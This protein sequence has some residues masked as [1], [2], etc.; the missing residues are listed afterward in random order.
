MRFAKIL[1]AALV[2]GGVA[3][4]AEYVVP[5]SSGR[6]I[7][8]PASQAAA[9]PARFSQRDFDG[10]GDGLQNFSVMAR[11]QLDF[12]DARYG[13]VRGAALVLRDRD[14]LV[15]AF[16]YPEN[17]RGRH[18][19]LQGSPM[20]LPGA[21]TVTLDTHD[22]YGVPCVMVQYSNTPERTRVFLRDGVVYQDHIM[23]PPPPV[24]QTVVVREEYWHREPVQ[25]RRHHRGK[26]D[27]RGL[28]GDVLHATA[29][30]FH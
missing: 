8:A 10:R 26:F 29:R 14:N 21:G 15:V 1:A 22:Q 4:A 28:V 13:M 25:E 24:Q 17:D 18:Y 6:V 19:M 30:A 27:W 16:Y 5:Y 2:L 20:I 3:G 12:P 7:Y 11:Y 23:P 9:V